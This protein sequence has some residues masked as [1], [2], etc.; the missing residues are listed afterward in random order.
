M[1]HTQFYS[2]SR[3]I[4]GLLA[5]IGLGLFW[6]FL[7][8]KSF[9]NEQQVAS[10]R[11]SQISQWQQ[12]RSQLD[13]LENASFSEQKNFVNLAND[14]VDKIA[15]WNQNQ[16]I[17][18]VSR[19]GQP[20]AKQSLE[21]MLDNIKNYLNRSATTEQPQW[22]KYQQKTWKALSQLLDSYFKNY[23]QEK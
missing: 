17:T 22:Q 5:L 8:P 21:R 3:K 13:T 9:E 11:A 15:L 12:F 1:G 2:R 19:P 20:L 14:I 4:V 10:E 6:F 23:L 18:D 7:G 16:N